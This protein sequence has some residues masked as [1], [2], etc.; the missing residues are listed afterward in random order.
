MGQAVE[1]ARMGWGLCTVLGVAGKGEKL[2]IIPR[3]L[4]TGRKV[5]GGSFGGAKGRTHVPRL[6][7]MYLQG[8][9][10]LEGFIS[11]RMP[12]DEVNKAF[13]LMEAQDGIRSVI[14]F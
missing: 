13:H 6:V 7:D 3:F 9:I 14:Q 5:Q 12:L 11:H 2:Q 8:E 1:A 10:D 4:I